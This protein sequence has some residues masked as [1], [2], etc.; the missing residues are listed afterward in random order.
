M[1]DFKW[2]N[3]NT[4]ETVLSTE[5]NSLGDSSNKITTTAI[6]NTDKYMYADF[7]LSV[8]TQGAARPTVQS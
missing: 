2:G 5:L 3:R 1:A 7:E 6:S 4:E 8:A